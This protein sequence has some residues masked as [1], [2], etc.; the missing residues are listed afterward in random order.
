MVIFVN[1]KRNKIGVLLQFWCNILITE[2]ETLFLCVLWT[3]ILHQAAWHVK[4]L[5]GDKPICIPANFSE[6]SGVKCYCRVIDVSTGHHHG[7]SE[8]QLDF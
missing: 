6:I 5:M 3:G 7:V 8:G 4:T 2:S 1:N